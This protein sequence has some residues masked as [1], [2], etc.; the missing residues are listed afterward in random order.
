MGV[1]APMTRTRRRTVA[2]QLAARDN[3]YDTLTAP[4]TER[5]GLGWHVPTPADAARDHAVSVVI[6]AR[7]A[8]HGLPT[9]LDALAGQKTAAA[10]QVIV[11]DD[12]SDDNTGYLAARHPATH[13]VVRLA[14]RVGSGA[15]RNAGTLLARADTVL[16]LDADMVLP[17]HVLADFAA[18][19]H[20]DLVLVGFRHNVSH[21]EDADGT[22]VMPPGEPV[23]EADHRVVWRPPVGVPLFY[24][25]LVLDEPVDGRPL[26]HTDEF[27]LL[28]HAGR[29]HDWDLPRMVVTALAAMPRQRVV[30]VGGFDPAFAAFWGCEDTYLGALLI[31]T[32]AKVVPLRQ[33][34]GFHLDPPDAEQAWQTKLATSAG[35]IARYW[36]LLDQPIPGP[37]SS[38]LP[39]ASRLLA[40]GIRLK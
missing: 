8:A 34:R 30:Q 28:G 37:G 5:T 20:P 11:I 2:Q 25:G 7:N 12:A 32:G 38:H 39:G 23:L 40:E 4:F 10:V 15:A 16:Y 19:A 29:Y 3:V 35:N 13:N 17:D 1:A 33:A 18:R 22:P 24:T 14:Q 26:A 36:T 27:R 21:Q 6:P 31:A 9:V